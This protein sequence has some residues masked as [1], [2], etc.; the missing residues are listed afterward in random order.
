M[1]RRR[2]LTVLPL[3][4]GLALLALSISPGPRAATAAGLVL[5]SDVAYDIRPD[6][7][8]VHVSWQ[9]LVDNQDPQTVQQQSG[10]IFF[11]DSLS[12]PVLRGADNL[13]ARAG[14]A[15]LPVSLATG[16][17]PI[18]GADVSFDRRLFFGD[19]YSFTLD[20]DI[21]S[22]RDDSLLVT[23]YYVFL[24]AISFG[25]ESTVSVTTPSDSAWE[26]NVE[27]GD[28]GAGPVFACQASSA[29]E[30]TL[31]ALVE[32]SRPDAAVTAPI[33]SPLDG[34]E[35][36]L[37]YFQE[38]EEWA[39]HLQDL[40]IAS[41][42]AMEQLYGFPYAGPP[43]I[44]IAE[45]G[46]QII[47]GY[48]GLTSCDESA[49]DIA[50]SPVTDDA[51]AL[52]ELAHLW[53]DIYDKRWLAEGFANLV[54]LKTAAILG[55][56]IVR[57]SMEPPEGNGLDLRLDEWGDVTSLIAASPDE[58]AVEQAGYDR[59]YRF[60]RLLEDTVGLEALQAVNAALAQ[61]KGQADSQRF[62]D[63]LEDASG[64]SLDAQIQTWVFP[65]SFAPL[66][67]QRRQARDRL[68]ALSEAVAA[69]GLDAGP[70]EA[71]RELISGWRFD[72]A[73]AALDE[74]EAG[75]AVYLQLKAEIAALREGVEAAGLRF[76]AVIDEAIADWRFGDLEGLVVDAGE[77]LAA[78]LRAGKKV[79]QP[80]S[81][82]QRIGLLFRDPQGALDTAATDFAA[83][84][85][86]GSVR[87]SNRAFDMIHGAGDAALVRLLI[88][89]A[90]VV[91]LAAGVA[92]IIWFQ[93]R[94]GFP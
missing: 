65:D 54:A 51:T 90:G 20:Y 37:T 43:A 84:D 76:P 27:P 39:R 18:A 70:P 10:T 75:L 47:L 81:L 12:L 40:V 45:R 62:L 72:E 44:S 58:E 63:T 48:E 61:G 25:Q 7:G 73:L 94:R 78:Y 87:N 85:F 3:A 92:A 77:A 91:A 13:T 67:A 5:T 74:A 56:G 93:R 9:V 52:H 41:L 35:I 30:V 33:A 83:G 89:L 31:A 79:D 8:P 29:E 66:L 1:S 22:A 49:C 4:L 36:S 55:P 38:E 57:G 6:E 16:D 71:I 34:V 2:L 60:L 21:P 82:W 88:V 17:G 28:C 46:R 11:Y 14:G 80:R 26:V 69:E 68:A 19:T 24:P 15:S 23:R 59:S 53:S 64:Q 32:V 86:E 42:P 50:V